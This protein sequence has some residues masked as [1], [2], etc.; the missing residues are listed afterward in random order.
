MYNYKNSVRVA[1]KYT[2]FVSLRRQLVLETLRENVV[3]GKNNLDILI[4]DNQ[5]KLVSHCDVSYEFIQIPI[6]IVTQ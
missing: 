4:S 3:V 2:L 6:Y 5:K 1:I